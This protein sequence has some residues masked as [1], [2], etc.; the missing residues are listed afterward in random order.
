[1]TLQQ[2]GSTNTVNAMTYVDRLTRHWSHRFEVRQ[3]ADGAWLVDFGDGSGLLLASRG[4]VIEMT[5]FGP[6][7]DLAMLRG[8]TEEHIDRFAHREGGLAY[9]WDPAVG[10]AHPVPGV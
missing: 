5:I 3:Q 9:R 6:E 2:S 4:E 8:V 1:M 7:P 10:A